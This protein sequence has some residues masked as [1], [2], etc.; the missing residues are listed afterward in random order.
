MKG[1]IMVPSCVRHSVTTHT[2][3]TATGLSATRDQLSR[4]TTGYVQF[5]FISSHLQK[6]VRHQGSAQQKHKERL[7]TPCCLKAL[8]SAVLQPCIL[9]CYSL[10]VCCVT[11]LQLQE[12]YIIMWS[13]PARKD[14]VIKLFTK[15]GLL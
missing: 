2:R 8:H 14:L 11:A 7:Q 4:I 6:S 15:D 12:S 1:T 13:S 3:C 5:S 10:A 9:L